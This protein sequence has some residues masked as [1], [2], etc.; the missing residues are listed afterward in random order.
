V[1][2]LCIAAASEHSFHQTFCCDYDSSS[3]ALGNQCVNV[4]PR[5]NEHRA[6][7]FE[8]PPEQIVHVISC[9]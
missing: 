9:F 2:S 5:A 3:P 7:M 1:A 8:G 6:E 4:Y